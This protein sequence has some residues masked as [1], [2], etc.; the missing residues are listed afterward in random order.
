MSLP[1]IRVGASAESANGLPETIGASLD[2]LER[3]G[4]D[5]V[6]IPLLWLELVAGG[7]VMPD[8]LRELKAAVSGRPFTY[9]GH[10]AI[11]INFTS[12]PTYLPLHMSLAKAYLDIAG[13]VGCEHVVIHTGFYPPRCVAPEIARLYDQ[14]RTA[15][16]RSAITRANAACWS[17]SRTSMPRWA[18]GSRR[19]LRNSPRN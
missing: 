9:T 5:T 12:E 7:K 1:D 4:V 6:E 11:G 16:M 13:E 14:Q 18:T 8:R 19:P 3:E 17:A 15:C 2:R 10:A